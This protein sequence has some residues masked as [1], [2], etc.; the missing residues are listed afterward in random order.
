MK[1]LLFPVLLT[2]GLP[3]FGQWN[4]TGDVVQLNGNNQDRPVTISDAT[5]ESNRGK[6]AVISN[7]NGN[8]NEFLVYLSA[9][10]DYSSSGAR[11][12][13][14]TMVGNPFSGQEATIVQ[15]YKET[16]SSSNLAYRIT[17]EGNGIFKGDLDLNYNDARAGQALQVGG[18]QAIWYNDDHFS[19]GF[20]GNWN[21]FADA[22]TIGS[23]TQPLSSVGLRI[24]QSKDLELD[25]GSMQVRGNT[26]FNF[27]NDVGNTIFFRN[28]AGTTIS[29]IGRGQNFMRISDLTQL[30]LRAGS[31][32][33]IHLRGGP[34][35][36]YF[37]SDIGLDVSNR[38]FW[39]ASN[40]NPDME[41]RRSGDQ[42]IFV[43]RT[44]NGKM[45]IETQSGVIDINNTEANLILSGEYVGINMSNPQ[46][47]LH[48]SGD[49]G[50]TGEFYAL[51]DERAK[52]HIE[53]IDSAS[54]MIAKF[55]PVT[56]H[57]KSDIENVIL[58][59]DLQYG[60]IAQEVEAVF[61]TLVKTHSV[62]KEGEKETELLGVNYQSIIPILIK[63]LQNEQ[64]LRK[65]QEER[66]DKLENQLIQLLELMDQRN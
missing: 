60:L 2:L 4:T 14:L 51:S 41:I 31:T 54:E 30:F 42:F 66:I 34:R 45:N 32:D 37:T 39:G 7:P 38:V 17:T 8:F 29:S 50:I 58:P 35:S 40:S 36:A 47:A 49:V 9:D 48:V 43:N 52:E 57:Y 11:G 59:A 28:T 1:H 25:G 55:R 24:D 26:G 12:S 62:V 61:P 6:L 46:H 33:L 3:L 23:G 65:Q 56:Y 53:D 18:D 27:Y 20:G 15:G 21:R 44:S 63:A 16:L 13:I 64:D 5:Q 10:T 19:W 22:I